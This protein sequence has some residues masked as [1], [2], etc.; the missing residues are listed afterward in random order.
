M[1]AVLVTMSL[2]CGCLEALVDD[3]GRLVACSGD[4]DRATWWCE[5]AIG[6]DPELCE[7]GM[8]LMVLQA[9]FP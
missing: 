3:A 8:A 4:L 5:C 1:L 9:G 7:H 2:P 6:A